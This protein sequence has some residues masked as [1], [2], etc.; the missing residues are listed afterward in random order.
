[1]K[2]IIIIV[3]MLGSTILAIESYVCRDEKHRIIA[4]NEIQLSTSQVS[5]VLKLITPML[6][7]VVICLMPHQTGTSQSVS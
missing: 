2:E 1:M 7:V 3:K 6:F 4:P 5:Q